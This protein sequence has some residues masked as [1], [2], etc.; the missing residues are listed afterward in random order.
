MP[1]PSLSVVVPNYNHA[2]LLPHCL[3]ALLAQ[4]VQP[5]E[6]IVVDDGSTDNSVSVIEGY[7]Q[8]HAHIRLL[9]NEKNQGVVPTVNRGVDASRGEFI[10]F[11]PAD[12]TSHPILFEKSLSLLQA[13][14][15]AFRLRPFRLP[16]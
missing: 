9:R 1:P 10:N 16:S 8:R 4:T 6:I 2:E 14:P 3:D 12:D 15:R 13:H 7:C 11:A 5:M